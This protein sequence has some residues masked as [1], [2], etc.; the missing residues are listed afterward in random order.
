MR[1]CP[2]DTKCVKGSACHDLCDELYTFYELF[3]IGRVT[4]DDIDDYIDKWHNG[5]SRESVYDYLG[6]TWEQYAKWVDKG[7]IE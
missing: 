1:Y 3:S 7:V 4:I 2:E 6:L 5:D